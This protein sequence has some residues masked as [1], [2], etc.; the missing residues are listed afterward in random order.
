MKGYLFSSPRSLP[1][2]KLQHTLHFLI[3]EDNLLFPSIG[4]GLGLGPFY[5]ESCRYNQ[6]RISNK[7][8]DVT[9]C[10]S[11]WVIYSFMD[12]TSEPNP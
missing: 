7:L 5:T 6:L 12:I 8:Y 10:S 1:L 11:E 3:K 4:M 2:A 9:T